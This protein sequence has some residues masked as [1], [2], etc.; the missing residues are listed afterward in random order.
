MTF[1]SLNKHCKKREHEEQ[2]NLRFYIKLYSSSVVWS[3]RETFTVLNPLVCA[4]WGIMKGSIWKCFSKINKD[5]FFKPGYV[6]LLLC[7]K[8]NRVLSSALDPAEFSRPLSTMMEPQDALSQ[9]SETQCFSG[10]EDGE[11]DLSLDQDQE[12]SGIITPTRKKDIKVKRKG[13]QFVWGATKHHVKLK[14]P[15]I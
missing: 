14:G 8:N 5:L 10:D 15:S 13:V 4:S 2:R 1:K 7:T 6:W 12:D 3:I 9:R 11:P